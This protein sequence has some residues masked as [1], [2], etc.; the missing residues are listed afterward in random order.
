M[1]AVQR[2]VKMPLIK[3]ISG[4]RGTIGGKPGDS[5]SPMDTVKFTSAY[6]V[7]LKEQS[8]KSVHTVVVGRDAVF[9]IQFSVH[10]RLEADV[11]MRRG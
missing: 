4:I 9:K 11:I 5:L 1:F 6:S 3:T 8:A 2:T 7:W 10:H